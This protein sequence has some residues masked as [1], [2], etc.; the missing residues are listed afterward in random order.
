MSDQ[1]KLEARLLSAAELEVV[2]A[3][4]PPAIEQASDEQ[5]KVL[6]QRLRPARDR[7]KDIGA[8]Q[9]RETRGKA[10]SRGTKPTRDNT[11]T[12]AKAQVLG[13]AIERVEEE[14]SRRENLTTATTTQ[15]DLSRHA[16]E[17][18]LSHPAPPHPGSG[19]SASEGMKP[20]ERQKPLRVG[21]SKGEVGRVSQEGKVAQARKDSDDR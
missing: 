10:D 6:A 19:R 17:L 14:L 7:A 12:L 20:K 16:L 3:T 11:G 1:T 8:R 13:E 4:R 21:A 5:L 18:K 2:N 15:A 9:K